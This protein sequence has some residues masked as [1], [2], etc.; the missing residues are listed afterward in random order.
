MS[1]GAWAIGVPLQKIVI[2]AA[3]TTRRAT[4]IIAP[5]IVDTS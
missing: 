1:V 5:D 2:A 4:V 3:N